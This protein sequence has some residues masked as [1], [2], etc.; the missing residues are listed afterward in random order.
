MISSSTF[1]NGSI[2]V[3][4]MIKCVCGNIKGLFGIEWKKLKEKESAARLSDFSLL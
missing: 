4:I 3:A 2:L 1:R